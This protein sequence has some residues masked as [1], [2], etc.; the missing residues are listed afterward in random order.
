MKNDYCGALPRMKIASVLSIVLVAASAFSFT[1]N[2]WQPDSSGNWSGKWSDTDHW[3]L[4]RLP[5][6]SADDNAIFDNQEEPYTVEIDGEY[7]VPGFIKFGDSKLT[8]GGTGMVTF[9]GAGTAR[10]VQDYVHI[11]TGREVSFAG[12]VTIEE[13]KGILIMDGGKVHVAGSAKVAVSD[14]I[15]FQ[16]YSELH[17]EENAFVQG[18]FSLDTACTNGV[19]AMSGGVLNYVANLNALPVGFDISF[20]GGR[21]ILN[22]KCSDYRFLPQG[23]SA[24]FEHVSGGT[25]ALVVT[26]TLVHELSG[27]YIGTNSSHDIAF[28]FDDVVDI[29][30]GG[31]ID[32][33]RWTPQNSSS[34]TGI[35]DIVHLG[36]GTAIVP[37]SGYVIYPSDMTIGAHGDYYLSSY[38]NVALFSGQVVFDTLDT[39]DRTTTHTVKFNQIGETPG[40]GFGVRG[41]GS[42]TIYFGPI[43]ETTPAI[44]NIDVDAGTTLLFSS[45]S[46]RASVCVRTDRFSLGANSVFGFKANE[47]TLDAADAEID[48]SA[49]INIDMSGFTANQETLAKPLLMTT[50]G[51]APELS[52][53][54]FSNNSAWEIKKVDNVIYAKATTPE[55]S[56]NPSPW[57]WTGAISDDWSDGR[58]WAGN[59]ASGPDGST[60]VYFTLVGSGRNEISIPAGGASVNRISGGGRNETWYRNGEPYLFKG[61]DLTVNSTVSPAYN[62]GIYTC[63]KCPLIFDCKV[64]GTTLG[65]IGNS[66][67]AFRGGMTANEL[68]FMSEVR[69]G[70]NVSVGKVTSSGDSYTGTRVTT[71]TVLPGGT[72][73]T[74]QSASNGSHLGLRILGGATATFAQT[75]AYSSATL[76]TSYQVDGRLEFSGDLKLDVPV[77][78]CGTGRVDVAANSTGSGDGRITMK[79]GVTLSPVTWSTVTNVSSDAGMMSWSVA[80]S[81]TAVL[82]P[83]GDIV[84]G[85]AAVN[86]PTTSASDRALRIGRRATLTV[87]TDDIDN[88]AVSHNVSFVDPVEAATMAKIVKTGSGKLTLASDDNVFAGTSGID[89]RGGTL[90]WTSAQSLG[91]LKV[92]PG[93]TLEFSAPTLTVRSDL[94]LSGVRIVLA[95]GTAA[96]ENGYATVVAV[97][98]GCAISGEPV[99]PSGVRM[100]ICE[101]EGGTAVQVRKVSGLRIVIM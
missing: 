85:P 91:T 40:F 67:V 94:D 93:A 4:G 92:S 71:L 24:V 1:N 20:T 32:V 47:Y 51:D 39:F 96:G 83:R 87:A 2:Y 72:L 8:P 27:S 69:L 62:T 64:I 18:R 61:G 90:A 79:G 42:Q 9:T 30:G 80:D 46:S 31:R 6:N 37:S 33:D 100:Q 29:Y 43:K 44:W 56:T 88:P 75:F 68:K 45:V 86:S 99:L 54:S 50:T 26:N 23:E 48:P 16:D 25:S 74:T 17:I 84:Y 98:S 10:Q 81:Q 101:I 78:V 77:V 95:P 5:S 89:V 19:F 60:D 58:N 82:A 22:G 28:R 41:G 97:P 7:E 59:G 57:R 76:P 70:G 53:I 52:Q 35:V 65:V 3:S 66:Y 21:I 38:N 11:Y 73:T 63:S 14:V 55:T 49:T 36:I 13:N 34:E 12:E 15:K